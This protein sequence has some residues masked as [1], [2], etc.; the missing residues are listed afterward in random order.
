MG[1]AAHVNLCSRWAP[2][3]LRDAGAIVEEAAAL[4]LPCLGIVYPR[5]EDGH[6]DNNFDLLRQNDPQAYADLVAHC[7]SVGVD[8]GFDVIKTQ[9]V[10]PPEVFRPV[11]RAAD[12]VPIVIAGGPRVSDEKL[13]EM[14]RAAFTAG[15]AG[16]SFGRNL[17]GRIEAAALVQ[18]IR[19]QYHECQEL[20]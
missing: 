17:F 4:G 2:Q 18:Q 11:V 1:V 13:L 10:G 5:A 9:F 3:M 19:Q 15:V 20:N 8:L 6:F 12:G 7:V 16:I 14:T